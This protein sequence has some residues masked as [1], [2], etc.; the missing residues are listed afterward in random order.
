MTEAEEYTIATGV[1]VLIGDLEEHLRVPWVIKGMFITPEEN[2]KKIRSMLREQL[3]DSIY[4]VQS[5]P[6]FLETLAVG[7]S[8]GAGL[9]HALA[10]LNLKPENAIAF[11]DEENDLPMFETAGFSAA[12]ANAKEAV[13]AAAVFQIPSNSEDGV[14][15]FLEEQFLSGCCSET[16]VS[17]QLY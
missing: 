6:V 17:K 8:K 4:A 16:E 10:Y 12:P 3:G 7:V 14:A 2:H 13:R 1:D 15:A 5:S 11:G 9:A